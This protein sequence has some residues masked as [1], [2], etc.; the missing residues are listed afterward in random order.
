[1]SVTTLL[2]TELNNSPG[3]FIYDHTFT[4]CAHIYFLTIYTSQAFVTSLH[5]L[6]EEWDMN[7]EIFSIGTTSRFIANQLTNLPAARARRKVLLLYTT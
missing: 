6:M 1:M 2:D 3:H 5:Y 4:F 7:E